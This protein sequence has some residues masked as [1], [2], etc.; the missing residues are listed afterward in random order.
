[1]A[2]LFISYA[3]K[4]Q[5]LAQQLEAA[6]SVKG[7]QV[8][9][10][11]T[12]LYAGERWP[13]ALGNAIASTDAL[14][15]LWSSEAKQSD[16]VEL[17]WNI[18]VAMKKPVMPCVMDS[19]PLSATLKP[20]H[21]ISW[22]DVQ[23]T[24]EEIVFALEQQGASIQ[25]EQQNKLLESLNVVTAHKP[26]EVLHQIQIVLKEPKPFVERAGAWVTLVA[27]VLAIMFY[28]GDVPRKIMEWKTQEDNFPRKL[29]EYPFEGQVLD[30]QGKGLED[31]K[32][33]LVVPGQ[34][35]M[36]SHTRE[37]GVFVFKVLTETEK[38]ATLHANKAG[39]KSIRRNVTIPDQRYVLKM[40]PTVQEQGR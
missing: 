36:T 4:Q 24:A 33:S 34:G 38:A 13:K 19:T 8:W 15:L 3:S 29:H 23:P 27:G 10:D 28:L 2:S 21:C 31:V 11:K 5:D 20:L 18:A 12:K 35:S 39:F 25:N 14:V 16:F 22:K 37:T 1:M 40:E 17:E 30:S 7:I 6:L 26:Q 9:R 32:V